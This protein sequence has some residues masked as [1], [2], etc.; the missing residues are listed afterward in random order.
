MAD[1]SSSATVKA[2]FGAKWILG[3]QRTVTATRPRL[4]TLPQLPPGLI[5]RAFWPIEPCQLAES[6]L[7]GLNPSGDSIRGSKHSLLLDF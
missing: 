1:R 4:P 5:L 7:F 3:G 2:K 6:A